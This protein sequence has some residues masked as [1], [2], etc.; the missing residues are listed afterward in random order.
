MSNTY[1]F[2]FYH[3]DKSDLSSEVVDKILNSNLA[4]KSRT[5]F[6]TDKEIRISGS[7]SQFD[8]S[9]LDEISIIDKNLSMIYSSDIDLCEKLSFYI[10]ENGSW[11]FV[12][13]EITKIVSRAFNQQEIEELRQHKIQSIS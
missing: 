11:K 2:C 13:T 3:E 5:P 6:A 10:P 9:L 8:V 12:K 7:F 1:Y 4:K